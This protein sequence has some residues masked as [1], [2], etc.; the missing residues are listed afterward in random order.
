VPF[1]LAELDARLTEADRSTLAG[2]AL[3]DETNAEDLSLEGKGYLGTLRRMA[4]EAR[5]IALKSSI[6]SAE[7][8]RKVADAL[9]LCQELDRLLEKSRG[10]GGVQ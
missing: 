8:E 9:R 10:A 7:R 6:A 1:G 5:I 2:I 3:A 4:R